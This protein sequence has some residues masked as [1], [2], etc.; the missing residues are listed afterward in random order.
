MN[1]QGSPCHT[2]CVRG[3]VA[4]LHAP[5]NFLLGRALGRTLGTL[6]G[7]EAPRIDGVSGRD[8]LPLDLRIAEV[9]RQTVVHLVAQ[10]EKEPR[11]NYIA[12]TA[13]RHVHT[14]KERSPSQRAPYVHFK[15]TTRG[16]RASVEFLRCRRLPVHS[17]R[18]EDVARRARRLFVEF[19]YIGVPWRLAGTWILT[20]CR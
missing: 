5:P 13:S 20:G 1:L 8:A 9:Y 4:A 14:R 11:W 15:H 7:I 12:R 18:L 19:E 3:R 6:E 16:S 2:T 10:S 17:A